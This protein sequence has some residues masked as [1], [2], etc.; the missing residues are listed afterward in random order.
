MQD[1]SSTHSFTSSSV[2]SSKDMDASSTRSNA[3]LLDEFS[4]GM[5]ELYIERIKSAGV[6]WPPLDGY[7][8]QCVWT[9]LL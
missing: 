3:S 9:W 2:L 6:D 1:D 4:P 8:K 5:S 7:Y